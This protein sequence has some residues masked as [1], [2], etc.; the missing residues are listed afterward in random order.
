[1]AAQAGSDQ[2]GIGTPGLVPTPSFRVP[3]YCIAPSDGG[4]ILRSQYIDPHSFMEAI[5]AVRTVSGRC[6]TPMGMALSRVAD[7][8]VLWADSIA[9]ELFRE[10]E[11][12]GPVEP[13][14]AKRPLS[15]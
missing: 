3:G 7:S 1:M 5:E 4:F 15:N 2:D 12:V 11:W 13:S 10:P 14:A 6:I 9:V 8:E